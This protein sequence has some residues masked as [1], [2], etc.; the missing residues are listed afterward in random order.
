[1][2]EFRL[3]HMYILYYVN[4]AHLITTGIFP[5]GSLIVLNY[6]VYSHLVER[7][8]QAESLGRPRS[9]M[10]FHKQWIYSKKSLSRFNLCILYF[11]GIQTQSHHFQ[12]Q[13]RNQ[14]TLENRQVHMLF[15][16]VILFF[17]GYALRFVLNVNELHS[18]ISTNEEKQDCPGILPTWIHVSNF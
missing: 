12:L 5:V 15:G 9:Y 14:I 8:R 11:K 2:N 6:L 13:M 4:V 1:M 17:V 7:R 10:I 3:D 18:I 16:V